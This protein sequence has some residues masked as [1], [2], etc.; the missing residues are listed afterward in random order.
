MEGVQQCSLHCKPGFVCPCRLDVKTC[1]PRPSGATAITVWALSA[2]L[3]LCVRDKRHLGCIW[4]SG[5]SYSFAPYKCSH[6]ANGSG[7]RELTGA[8]V[9]TG[10]QQVL[11]ACRPHTSS[12]LLCWAPG[13]QWNF[14][15]SAR[16][17]GAGRFLRKCFLVA[18]PGPH[19]GLQISWPF[20]AER[21]I[22]IFMIF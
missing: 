18:A 7:P 11:R 20:L 12:L 16:T 22:P 1:D 4:A 19:P 5:R 2:L 8:A 9:Q 6:L 17:W 10:T 21:E 13:S 15:L 14:G 3:R